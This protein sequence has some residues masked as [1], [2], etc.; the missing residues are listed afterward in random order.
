M[1]IQFKYIPETDDIL[2]FL[3]VL[4][5]SHKAFLHRQDGSVAAWHAQQFH[6]SEVELEVGYVKP[7]G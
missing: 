3:D 6:R 4:S 1:V 5:F 7:R 2:V